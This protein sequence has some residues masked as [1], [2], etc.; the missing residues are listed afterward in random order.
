MIEISRAARYDA[1]AST[2]FAIITDPPRY[3]AW[4]PG[5]ESASLAGEDTFRQGARIRQ[6]RT[7]MGRRTEIGLTITRHVPT[8]LV[9]L[10]TGPG[11]TPA[12]R[13]AYRLRPDGD[14][15][16]LEF[17][18][19]LDGI[20]AMGEH[21]ARAQLTRQTQEM[22]ERLATIAASRQPPCRPTGGSSDNSTAP[23][24]ESR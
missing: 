24:T 1:P 2:I 20:H 6:F 19:T 7:V 14:G 4:Q 9:T 22:L 3:P 18:L 15:C 12:V 17:R 10:A 21:L 8:E 16:R 11:A 5:V 23:Y 13:E